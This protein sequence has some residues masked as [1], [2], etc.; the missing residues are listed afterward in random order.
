MPK[1]EM[2]PQ[3]QPLSDR[4]L[5]VKVSL[6]GSVAA[7]L[8]SNFGTLLGQLATGS[9]VPLTG[10]QV[11]SGLQQNVPTDLHLG[12]SVTG[13]GSA[14]GAP[15][16]QATSHVQSGAG[17]P[18]SLHNTPIDLHIVI[19]DKSVHPQSKEL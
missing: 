4:P 13:C 5:S 17:P 9:G 10:S 16:P 8:M 15:V 11:Q 6:N 3:I 19:E 1:Q 18:V 14:S 12:K 2:S 7:S